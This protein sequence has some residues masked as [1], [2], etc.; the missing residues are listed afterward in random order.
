MQLLKGLLL[1]LLVNRGFGQ[2]DPLPTDDGA[3]DTLAEPVATDAPDPSVL[4]PS[5]PPPEESPV[6]TGGDTGDVPTVTIDEPAPSDARKPADEPT[7]E[8]TAVEDPPEPS[9]I[10]DEPAETPTADTEQPEPTD[11]PL[12]SEPEPAPT[13]TDVGPTGT[14]DENPAETET[15]GENTQ[16]NDQEVTQTEAEAG[17]I[18]TE[19]PLN[20]AAEETSAAEVVPTTNGENT[21]TGDQEATQTEAEAPVIATEAPLNSAAAET[22]VEEVA[23]SGSEAQ[24]TGSDPNDVP[25]TTASPSATTQ[26]P[27]Y[28][29]GQD[30][31]SS[32]IQDVQTTTNTDPGDSTGKKT[33]GIVAPTETKKEDAE[34]TQDAEADGETGT[35]ENYEGPTDT[36]SNGK[37]EETKPG[38]SGAGGKGSDEAT[39]KASATATGDSPGPT[40]VPEDIPVQLEDSKLGDYAAFKDKDGE[41]V[42]VFSPPP[43]GEATCDLPPTGGD[44]VPVGEYIRLI[45]SVRLQQ[46]GG[47][48]VLKEDRTGSRL[49]VLVDKTQVYDQEL[50][51]TGGDLQTVSTEK[52]EAAKDQKIRMIQQSGDTPVELEIQ[53]ANL[54]LANSVKESGGDGKGGDGGKGGDD[55]KESGGSKG[56]DDSGKGNGGKDGGGDSGSG[57]GSGSG[58]GSGDG[59]KGKDSGDGAGSGGNGSGDGG[60]GS[61]SGGN[62]DSG[63]G[64]GSAS[65]TSDEGSS[66]S[67]TAGSEGA[68]NAAGKLQMVSELLMYSLTLA[69][70]FMW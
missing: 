34:G 22:P 67:A 33:Y 50:V 6:N 44:D 18:A 70:A 45:L 59:N 39:D 13:A 17:V 42:L 56:G 40:S 38:G 36:V 53:D 12:S 69:V 52:F 65:G 26:D 21:Q 23:T 63:S 61:G 19:A 16:T 7:P 60:S 24:T 5:A 3:V 25:A 62:S 51:G 48:A 49:K 27:N 37:P 2:T 31:T 1:G 64:S 15:N 20:S 43:N 9:D 14:L 10:P 8:P 68:V 41:T 4:E 11:Q 55:G 32:E 54:Q 57:S 29:V 30:T 58:D 66:P 46:V 28:V 47:N 35:Q